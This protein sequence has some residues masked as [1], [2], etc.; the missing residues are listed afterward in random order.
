MPVD[1]RSKSV[2]I[3]V[4][5]NV[6]INVLIEETQKIFLLESCIIQWWWL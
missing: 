4:P 6:L 2:L 5:I 1:K 3:N